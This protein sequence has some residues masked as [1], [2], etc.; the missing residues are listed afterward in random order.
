[1]LLPPFEEPSTLSLLASSVW[2]LEAV[3]L[4][5]MLLPLIVPLMWPLRTEPPLL[6]SC[7]CS[8]DH[9]TRRSYRY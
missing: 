3:E 8:W 6:N 5:P 4:L 1:M 7:R 2:P 9:R